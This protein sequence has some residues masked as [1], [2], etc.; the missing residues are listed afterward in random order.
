MQKRRVWSN[1]I[2]I[3]IVKAGQ[4]S[5]SCGASCSLWAQGSVT[6]FI[7]NPFRQA[8]NR[9]K[10]P[11]IT[12]ALK[13]KHPDDSQRAGHKMQLSP[14]NTLSCRFICS[15]LHRSFFSLLLSE[16]SEITLD[17][18]TV[19]LS[20]LT[21]QKPVRPSICQRFARREYIFAHISNANYTSRSRSNIRA[22]KKAFTRNRVRGN[23]NEPQSE[24]TTYPQMRD[25]CHNFFTHF[26][27]CLICSVQKF[28]IIFS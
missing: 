4:P 13:C 6:D 20:H 26:T 23:I 16:A 21:A 25:A 9:E 1:K 27:L 7:I 17:W 5:E 28:L 11:K 14:S 3:I 15:S 12:N 10:C 19:A 18:L 2:Y 8:E 24:K 22:S